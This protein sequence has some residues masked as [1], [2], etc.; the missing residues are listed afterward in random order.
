MKER[1]RRAGDRGVAD[2][3]AL[4]ILLPRLAPTQKQAQERGA[5]R[6]RK[7]LFYIF[8]D[9]FLCVTE[10]RACPAERFNLRRN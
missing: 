2:R 8:S 6:E 10:N 5:K 9:V 4:Q 3:Q 1:Q 7:L